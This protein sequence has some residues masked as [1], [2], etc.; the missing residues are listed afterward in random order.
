MLGA[1]H[2]YAYT[3]LYGWVG[4]FEDA[5][6]PP[7]EIIRNAIKSVQLDPSD[8]RAHRTAAAGYFFNKQLDMFERHATTAVELALTTLKYYRSWARC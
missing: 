4:H 8:P 2:V 3:V 1:R 5:P 6:V 7:A